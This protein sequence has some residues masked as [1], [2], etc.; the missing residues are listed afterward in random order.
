AIERLQQVGWQLWSA[1]SYRQLD[2]RFLLLGREIRHALRHRLHFV[3]QVRHASK[4]ARGEQ[5]HE[6]VLEDFQNLAADVAL[7]LL[8]ED[9]QQRRR[10]ARAEIFLV[11]SADL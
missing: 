6:R 5:V 11:L 8:L 7:A 9:I 1:Q 10:H 3:E 4:V 2:E